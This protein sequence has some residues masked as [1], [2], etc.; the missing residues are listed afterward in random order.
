ML[1]RSSSSDPTGKLTERVETTVSDSVKL[2][3][4][5]HW[6][7]LGYLSEAEYLRELI[8]KDLYGSF[9]RIQSIAQRAVKGHP[10]NTGNMTGA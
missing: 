8:F 3:M 9:H 6:R 10:E 7:L 2:D 5:C 1:S 4:T